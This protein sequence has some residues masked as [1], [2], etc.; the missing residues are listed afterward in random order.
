MTKVFVT[1]GEM[2]F[3]SQGGLYGLR[4]MPI[5]LVSAP[6]TFK[7]VIDRVLRRIA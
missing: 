6:V 4:V 1:L 3:A 2:L 5:G 7:G